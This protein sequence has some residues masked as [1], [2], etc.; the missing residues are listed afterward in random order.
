MAS[1]SP[2]DGRPGQ[3]TQLQGFKFQMGRKLRIRKG[4]VVGLVTGRAEFDSGDRDYLLHWS[5][6]DGRLV[7][8]WWNEQFLD[9][10]E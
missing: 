8:E 2:T 1:V 3:P 9:D 6:T 5:T 7:N 10:A 4:P